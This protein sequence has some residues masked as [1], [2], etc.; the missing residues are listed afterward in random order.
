MFGL[1][2]DA[3]EKLMYLHGHLDFQVH[4]RT[5]YI[6]CDGSVRRN[7]DELIKIL[8]GLTA[9]VQA[10][11]HSIENSLSQIDSYQQ[12]CHLI[13]HILIIR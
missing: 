8:D 3:G 2:E 4:F 9:A 10:Q 1:A 6:N 7:A 5:G 13:C 11:V 12:V